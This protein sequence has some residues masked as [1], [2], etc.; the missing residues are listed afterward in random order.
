MKPP[1]QWSAAEQFVWEKTC[2]G[3]E[4]D[5]NSRENK[6]L[7]PKSPDGWDESRR[8]SSEFLETILFE[9]PFR[10]EVTRKGVRII[11]AYFSDE[12][13]L[14]DGHLPWALGLQYSRF[15]NGLN[16]GGLHADRQVSLDGSVVKGKLNLGAASIGNALFMRKATF[17][18]AM[19][20]GAQITGQLS[21]IGATVKGTLDMASISIDNDLLMGGATFE[22]VMLRGAQIEGQLAMNSAR[23]KGMLIMDSV[24]IGGALLM[25]EGAT[26]KKVMLRGAQIEGQLA[27]RD[28]TVTDTLDMASASIGGSIL[29]DCATFAE[30]MLRGAQIGDQLSLIDARVKGK[31]DMDSVSVGSALLMRATA[32]EEVILRGAQIKGQLAMRDAT[33]TGTL[34]MTSAS[35]GNSL[36]M[37]GT[38]FAD[39]NLGFAT[40]GSMLN[41]TGGTFRALNLT[42]A[43][44]EGELRLITDNKSVNW[45]PDRKDQ[46]NE[47]QLN[48]Q[49]TQVGTLVDSPQSWP[50]KIEL[51]GFTY[52][53][54]GGFEM[55]ERPARDFIEWLGRDET[56]SFQP[57]Q[58][59]ATV[60]RNAGKSST[61]DKVLF[62]GKE[63]ERQ[64]AKSRR[65]YLEYL[66]LS[67][68]RYGLGY[69]ISSYILRPV[70]VLGLI[71][72]L[73]GCGVLRLTGEDQKHGKTVTVG[74]ER[75]VG[76]IGFWF[77]LDYLLP[78]IRLRE[79]HYTKVDLSCG[80]R[81]YFYIHQL[82]GYILVSFFI[83]V[84][85]GIIKPTNWRG[86]PE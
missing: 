15:E 54:L 85:S 28:A 2:A 29:M 61:A 52:R 34:D 11:G 6:G 72:T 43:T 77:S 55:S 69:R 73:F 57:Y 18:E 23:V 50:K 47:I 38:T 1:E 13:D 71:V 20:R 14:E 19:L 4:A 42:G 81:I 48:L 56:F 74:G 86:P 83:A 39:V 80:V 26:F 10:E 7:D 37:D 67:V 84:F 53:Q 64:N 68:L 58:Q 12:I 25:A 70:L 46:S 17:E 35:V 79:A 76:E 31:L 75:T 40:I 60:L 49:N 27:M 30:V 59:L 8:I 82:I 24:S 21:M 36:L 33:V 63:R 62:A 65:E 41:L 3:E 22:K 44:V 9:K 45:L 78:I 32:F 16:M 51:R 66:R 5:F